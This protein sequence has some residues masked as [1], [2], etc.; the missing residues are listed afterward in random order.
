MLGPLLAGCASSPPS[1]SAPPFAARAERRFDPPSEE[2]I[3]VQIAQLG[4]ID[5]SLRAQLATDLHASDPSIWPLL[6]EQFRATEAYR[7]QTL[8]RAAVEAEVRRLPAVESPLCEPPE[9]PAVMAAGYSEP[10]G[11]WRKDLCGAIAALEI[12]VPKTPMTTAEQAQA[13]RLRMLYAAAGRRKDAVQSADVKSN[14]PEQRFLSKEFEG[15]SAWLDADVTVGP[16]ERAAAAKPALLAAV[17]EL[18]NRAPLVVRHLTF[19]TE[20]QS[21]GC[22]KEFEKCA[23]RPDQEVLLY[24]EVENFVSESTEKGFHTSLRSNYEI[25]GVDGRR[26]TQRDF[27]T[28]EEYCRNPRQDYFIAYR[29]R[30][31]KQITP[32]R[33]KLQLAVEDMTSSKAGRAS[34]D[35]EIANEHHE[36]LAGS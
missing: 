21:Y 20:V 19:C 35:F 12:E 1:T 6:V 28:A 36:A 13:A 31:P 22:L 10:G 3:R 32:G 25:Y 34:V 16:S 7:R 2:A 11:D 5:E 29:L 30:L 27:A 33:Y 8:A 26:V 15:L 9:T 17:R 4:P 23:F 18:S 14:S 24:A